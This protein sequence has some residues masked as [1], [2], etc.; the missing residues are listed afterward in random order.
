MEDVLQDRRQEYLEG[1]LTPAHCYLARTMDESQ[2][3]SLVGPGH[4]KETVALSVHHTMYP[5]EALVLLT[6]VSLAGQ[7]VFL[8]YPEVFSELSLAPSEMTG[9]ALTDPFHPRRTQCSIGMDQS[10]SSHT[11]AHQQP[12][13]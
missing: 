11:C 2:A 8:H 5:K 10:L 13:N 4:P 3:A 1:L 9:K 7:E 6:E 12:E